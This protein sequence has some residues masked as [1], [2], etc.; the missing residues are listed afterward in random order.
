VGES[1]WS[2]SIFPDSARGRYVLPIKRQV[3]MAEELDAGDVATMTVEL[4]NLWRRPGVH[5]GGALHPQY[6]G[7]GPLHRNH[8]RCPGRGDE[9]WGAARRDATGSITRSTCSG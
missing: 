7:D 4:V 6:G 1:T 5:S 8:R 2:T 9:D 3:R